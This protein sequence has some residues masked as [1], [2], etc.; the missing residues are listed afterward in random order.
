MARFAGARTISENWATVRNVPVPV[1]GLSTALQ[2]IAARDDHTCALAS[3][4]TLCWGSS[5][6]GELGN[7]STVSSLVPVAVQ[8]LVGL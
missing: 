1:Q 6:Q 8:V 7:K 2:A 4:G 5:S 3:G